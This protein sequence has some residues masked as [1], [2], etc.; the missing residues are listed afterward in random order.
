[1][2]R[3]IG[4]GAKKPPLHRPCEQVCYHLRELARD[5]NH[6]A[7]S[8][9]DCPSAPSSRWKRSTRLA[10]M[11]LPKPA[12]WMVFSAFWAEAV[13]PERRTSQVSGLEQRSIHALSARPRPVWPPQSERLEVAGWASCARCCRQCAAVLARLAAERRHSEHR[14]AAPEEPRR[15]QGYPPAPRQPPD[16]PASRS[17]CS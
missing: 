14:Q 11:R 3:S 4:C 1:M 16:T 12:A 13:T 9:K 7:W 5:L 2:F 17:L 15:P 8:S 6:G 10:R